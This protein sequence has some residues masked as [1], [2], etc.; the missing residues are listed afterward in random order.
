MYETI[1]E[2]LSRGVAFDPKTA[3]AKQWKPFHEE[4]P[5]VIVDPRF[6]YGHPVVGKKKIPTAALYRQWLSEE[7]DIRR[8]SEWFG[9][10]ESAV[11]EAIAFE[12]RLTV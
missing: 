4:C 11:E 9:T 7:R 12:T 8:V 10:T 5:N 6:A 1:E 3:L 2:A